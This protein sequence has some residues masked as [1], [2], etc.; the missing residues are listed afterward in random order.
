ML[1]ISNNLYNVLISFKCH[2]FGGIMSHRS[3]INST[4]NVTL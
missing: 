3:V 4:E 2:N 1:Y